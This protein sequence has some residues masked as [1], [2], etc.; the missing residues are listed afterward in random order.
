MD[1]TCP[2]CGYH[3]DVKEEK[4]PPQAQMA[5]C[6]KCRHKFQFRELV[7]PPEQKQEEKKEEPVFQSGAKPDSQA[8]TRATSQPRAETDNDFWQGLHEMGKSEERAG[9]KAPSFPK[10]I[11]PPWEDIRKNG[12]I[13]GFLQTIGA[14]LFHP[15]LFF[16]NMRTGYGMLRP[17]IFYLLVIE[18]QLAFSLLL[19]GMNNITVI[20][21]NEMLG[22]MPV[23]I[24]PVNLLLLYPPLFAVSQF[25]VAGLNHLFLVLSGGTD[26]DFEATFRVA[27]YGSAPFIF[28]AVFTALFSGGQVISA[29]WS[30]VCIIL[31]YKHVHSVNFLRATMAVFFPLLVATVLLLLLIRSTGSV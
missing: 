2:E 20:Q 31:G 8:S 10:A 15:V 30:L 22:Q 17:L 14:V 11:F 29:T 1:I 27:C 19:Q 21:G 3:R 25:F 9:G 24:G 16:Q 12:L 7:S 5:T 18:I 4:L 23:E 28:S 13:A 26:K 6:P